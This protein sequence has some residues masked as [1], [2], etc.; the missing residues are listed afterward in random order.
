MVGLPEGGDRREV[1]GG[2]HDGERRYCEQKLTHAQHQ[3]A[4]RPRHAL[5]ILHPHARQRHVPRALRLQR[6]RL[7]WMYRALAQVHLVRNYSP[8][9]FNPQFQ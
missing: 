5:E 1:T 9:L 6:R 3:T 4:D 8:A 2:C 7:H